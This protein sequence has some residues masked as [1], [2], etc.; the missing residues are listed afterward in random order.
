MRTTLTSIVAVIAVL[1]LVSATALAGGGNRVGT[2]SADQLLIPV[3]ARG[4]ALGSSF[5]AG[6][7]GVNAI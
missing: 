3:G 7:S 1:T 6:I 5:S 2:A 4:I